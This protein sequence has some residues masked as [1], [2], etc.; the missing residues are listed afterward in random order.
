MSSTQLPFRSAN[1]DTSQSVDAACPEA[2][3]TGA[4]PG[5][6][7]MRRGFAV[8]CLSAGNAPVLLSVRWRVRRPTPAGNRGEASRRDGERARPQFRARRGARSAPVRRFEV[9]VVYVN[10]WHAGLVAARA[11]SCVDGCR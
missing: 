7:G 5:L 6:F 11:L 8:A 3:G 2:A 9:P 1:R 4:S 10:Q